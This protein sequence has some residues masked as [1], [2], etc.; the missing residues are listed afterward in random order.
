MAINTQED[1][2]VGTGEFEIKMKCPKIVY[3]REHL[4]NAQGVLVFP[5]AE[6]E[7]HWFNAQS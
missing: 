7:Y 6:V 4:I 1:Q 5:G 2:R 3:F